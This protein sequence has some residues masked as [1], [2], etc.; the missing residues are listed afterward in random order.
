V[1]FDRGLD[2]ITLHS[3]AH[4]YFRDSPTLITSLACNAFPA[5]H[6]YALKLA[7]IIEQK[8]TSSVEEARVQLSR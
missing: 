2:P 5:A 7:K 1:V 3:K 6:R 8:G 4:Y